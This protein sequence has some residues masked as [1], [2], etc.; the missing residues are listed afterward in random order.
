[1]DQIFSSSNESAS[2]Q[3][4]MISCQ[5]LMDSRIGMILKLG[6]NIVSSL[7]CRKH[8]DNYER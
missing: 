2:I 3:D 6:A 1:M 7:N 8:D 5:F 4:H